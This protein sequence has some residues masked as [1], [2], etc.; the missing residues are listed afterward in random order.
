M[1]L[2][3]ENIIEVLQSVYDPEIPVNIWDL[4]LIYDIAISDSDVIITMTFT[5]PT[6]PMM[7]DLLQQVHDTVAAI[8]GGRDVR[9]EL[10]WDPPWDLSRMSD[11]ARL[12]LDLTEQGW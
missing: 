3:R 5:S 1:E 11:A 7:E 10:V 6:C 4:G 12:E 9:V 8:S 2:T